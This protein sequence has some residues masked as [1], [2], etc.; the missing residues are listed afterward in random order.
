MMKIRNNDARL[1]IKNIN[2]DMLVPQDHI[3]LYPVKYSI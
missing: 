1:D 3:E 2:L